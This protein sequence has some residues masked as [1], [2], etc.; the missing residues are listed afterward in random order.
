V[1]AFASWQRRA[2]DEEKQTA[3][4]SRHISQAVFCTASPDC[5]T[6]LARPHRHFRRGSFF[7]WRLWAF[8]AYQVPASWRALSSTSRRAGQKLCL[9]RRRM[10]RLAEL[11]RDSRAEHPFLVRMAVLSPSRVLAGRRHR[12][13]VPGQLRR[14]TIDRAHQ[15]LGSPFG[16][17]PTLVPGTR[18]VGSL[19]PLTK[20][21]H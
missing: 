19:E 20:A 6:Q 3:H 12:P 11:R 18:S 15:F 4:P 9:D 14:S 13:T 7:R 21:P 17:V 10:H 16:A 2:L 8:L 5:S 1:D